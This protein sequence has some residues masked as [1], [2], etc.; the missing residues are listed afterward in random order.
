M[1]E[2]VEST[3]DDGVKF[4]ALVDGELVTD[5][6]AINEAARV[7]QDDSEDAQPQKQYATVDDV[8]QWE[9][10]R[11]E[12]AVDFEVPGTDRWFKIAPADMNTLYKLSTAGLAAMGADGDKAAFVEAMGDAVVQSAVVLPQL[13]NAALAALK[14]SDSAL[15]QAILEECQKVSHM[16]DLAQGLEGFF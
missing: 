4:E 8:K 1:S 5:E 6:E 13:D 16:E 15:Y 9:K 11:V 3:E 7:I 2:D 10:D 14:A 12:N